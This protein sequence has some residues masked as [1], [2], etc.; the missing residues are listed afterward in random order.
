M[1]QFHQLGGGCAAIICLLCLSAQGQLATLAQ[2]YRA[3]APASTYYV[4]TS[5]DDANDGQ[6]AG[7]PWVSMSHALTNLPSGSTLVLGAGDT[8]SENGLI[9]TN[10]NNVRF[11]SSAAN[12]AT[13]IG[14]TSYAALLI[15]DVSGITVDHLIFSATTNNTSGPDSTCVTNCGLAFFNTGNG[16]CSNIVVTNCIVTNATVGIAFYSTTSA[17]TGWTNFTV[18]YCGVSNAVAVGVLMDTANCFDNYL[19]TSP[20]RAHRSGEIADN[21][22]AWIVGSVNGLWGNGIAVYQTADT[23]VERNYI[24]DLAQFTDA[25]TGGGAGGVVIGHNTNCIVQ[26]NEAFNVQESVDNV[27]GVGFDIDFGNVDCALRY[28]YAHDC[29]QSG[30]YFYGGSSLVG[31]NNTACYNLCVNN[32]TARGAEFRIDGYQQG[33][34]IYNNTLIAKSAGI[35]INILLATVTG[36]NVIANNLLR[37]PTSNGTCIQTDD[38]YSTV[39]VNGNCY[40][41][42]ATSSTKVSQWHGNNYVSL[43]DFRAG[44]GKETGTGFNVIPYVWD[45]TLHPTLG[46]GVSTTT[47]TNQQLS[48]V[49][50][51]LGQGLDLTAYGITIPATDFVG[52]S[53]GASN[54]IGCYVGPNVAAQTMAFWYPFRES[55]GTYIRD[56]SGH[57]L[58]ATAASLAWTT[59]ESGSGYSLTNGSTG[60]L[61]S[62]SITA[63][64]NAITISFWANLSGA[65]SGEGIV[66]EHTV[67]YYNYNCA[68][69][70]SYL[71]ASAKMYVALGRASSSYSDANF[72][73]PSTDVWHHYLIVYDNTVNTFKAYVDGSSQTITYTRQ[74]TGANNFVAAAHNWFARSGGTVRLKASI[75]DVRLY[76]GDVSGN[77]A[78][79]YGDPR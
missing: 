17:T 3:A 32:A 19:S 33:M 52:K 27:D 66:W 64:T 26:Y 24:H 20:Q 15:Q 76:L 57:T 7:A 50:P 31:S 16:W 75:D 56:E 62:P 72:P 67:N 11:T 23:T 12:P 9:F 59:G 79:I 36:T 13:I 55:T 78:T 6:S 69:L 42:I 38:D 25:T 22:I 53:T 18:R 65:Q 58:N 49:S 40:D 74:N 44:T 35:G 29:E 70:L 34:K 8:F 51:L 68:F 63:G 30:L 21:E 1:Q 54:S 71:Q 39:A 77:V 41:L 2:Q 4:D 5:G 43:A 46:Y 28:N 37:A 48:P 60:T 47:L 45:D 14:T 61:T 10:A 73:A